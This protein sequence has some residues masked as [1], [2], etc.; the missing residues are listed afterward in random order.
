MI[1]DLGILMDDAEAEWW[2]CPWKVFI[3]LFEFDTLLIPPSS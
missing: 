1:V 3:H 2:K